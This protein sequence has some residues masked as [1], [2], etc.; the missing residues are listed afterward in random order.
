M[1]STPKFVNHYQV[2]RI[3]STATE[4]EI[5]KAFHKQSLLTHPDKMGNTPKNH[6]AF[7]AVNEAHRILSDPKL[8]RDYD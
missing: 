6:A 1:A 3:S 7:C 4:A 8:K 2:L 5:K